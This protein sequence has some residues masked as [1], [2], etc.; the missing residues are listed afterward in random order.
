MKL[1]KVIRIL[2]AIAGVSLAAII[3]VLLTPNT[4]FV[5]F[6]GWIIFIVALQAS[7]FATTRSDYYDWRKWFSK[8]KQA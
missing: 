7:F 4:S 3:T 8:R 5:A 1:S 2:I 6:L